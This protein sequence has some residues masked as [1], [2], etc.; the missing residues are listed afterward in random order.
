MCQGADYGGRR[1]KSIREPASDP[2]E[3]AQHRGVDAGYPHAREALAEGEHLL[4]FPV[5]QE[6]PAKG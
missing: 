3:L 4:L 5:D 2:R 6:D 1:K